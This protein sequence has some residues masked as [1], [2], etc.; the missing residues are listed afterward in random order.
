[1][2]MP[3]PAL[4]PTLGLLQ[5]PST[6]QRI[7]FLS[8]VHLHSDEAA[9]AAAWRAHLLH[10]PADAIVILGDL[11]EVWVGD[12]DDDP[13]VRRCIDTLAQAAQ[14]CPVYFMCGNRD[15]LAGDGLMRAS[16]MQPLSD[17]TVLAIGPT[18]WLLSHGDALCLEDTDYLTFRA[19]VRSDEWQRTFL[20]RPLAE[21]VQTAR[22]LRAQSEQRKQTQTQYA[23]VDTAAALHWLQ[24]AQ[25]EGLV[26]GHTHRANTHALGPG[27]WRWVLS[28]WDARSTPPRLEVS[29]W[30]RQTAPSERAGPAG[31][32]RL[33]LSA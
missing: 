25:C 4:P 7:D 23:D 12:D 33:P 8:D 22:A 13:F 9:T 19:Q 28:D 2:T 30:L 5:V 17:P 11:F 31:L 27:H 10:T 26:H 21:R 20:A 14:R 32:H 1:M 6:W 3:L 16:G 18:R 29:C 24:A 15:F